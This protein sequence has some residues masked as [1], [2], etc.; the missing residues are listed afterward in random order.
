MYTV[1]WLESALDTLAEVYVA[2]LAEERDRIGSGVESLNLRLAV[3]PLEEG[4][5]R[6]GSVRMAFPPLLAVRFRVDELRHQ[7]RVIGVGRY[8]R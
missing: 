3:S 6:G 1:L 8:G 5:S 4:E 7:V 2:A